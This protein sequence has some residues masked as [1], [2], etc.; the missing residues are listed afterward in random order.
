MI[1]MGHLEVEGWRRGWVLVDDEGI[2]VILAKL[3]MTI[4]VVQ[5]D[6]GEFKP[7]IGLFRVQQSADDEL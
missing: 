1:Y 2:P 7:P 4:V 6:V 5:S 3:S